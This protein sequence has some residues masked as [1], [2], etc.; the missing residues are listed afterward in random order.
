MI[1]FKLLLAIC[2]FYFVGYPFYFLIKQQWRNPERWV[3]SIPISFGLGLGLLPFMLF[4][5]SF[6][7]IK[8]S[9]S[10]FIILLSF[11]SI[12]STILMLIRFSQAKKISS[13][14][15]KLTIKDLNNPFMFVMVLIIIFAILF[16]FFYSLSK[17]I[18]TYD[19]LF[20]WAYKAKILYYERSVNT[21][22]FTEMFDTVVRLNTHPDYPLLVSF[23]EF[24]ICT[25]IGKYDD[26][27]AKVIFP[28]FFLLTILF[29]WQFNR[30]FYPLEY[31]ILSIVFFVTIP[32]FYIQR[33]TDPFVPGTNNIILGGNAELPLIFFYLVQ[34]IHLF[35]WIKNGGFSNLFIAGLFSAFASFTKNEGTGLLAMSFLALIVIVLLYF[36]GTRKKR[37]LCCF[38]YLLLSLLML[39]PWLIHHSYLPH[40]GEN[41]PQQLKINIFLANLQ[42]L[43]TIILKIISEF[44]KIYLWGFLWILFFLLTFL[45]RKEKKEKGFKFLY[46]VLLLNGLMIIGIYII[47]PWNL[48]DLALLTVLSRILFQFSPLVVFISFYQ[49]YLLLKKEKL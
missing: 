30:S 25:I 41:Y 18:N 49:F 32:F 16:S 1:F 10:N 6:A 21:P 43:P 46:L 15:T 2:L 35:K 31:R 44:S 26:R 37:L 8:L 38:S 3:D 9:N 5:L 34:I 28:F 39:I 42:R 47:S 11:F 22:S 17:P 24:H 23:L 27:L 13:P 12:I 48:K 29:F 36:K 45:N 33:I 20:H 4:Y 14:K 40:I 7:G 19:A